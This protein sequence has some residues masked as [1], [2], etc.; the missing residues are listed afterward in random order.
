MIRVGSSL[1]S[2][3]PDPRSLRF[4][5]SWLC[6]FTMR[7]TA[8]ASHWLNRLVMATLL[9]ADV[10]IG[11][12]WVGSPARAFSSPVFDTAKSLFSIDAYGIALLLSVAVALTAFVTAG[13]SWI[14]GWLAGP[15]IGGQWMFWSLLFAQGAIG[16]AGGS[17]TASTF[18]LTFA[19]LHC[20]A[21]LGIA[22]SVYLPNQRPR[23]R[24][25]DPRS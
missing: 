10:V 1:P 19:V 15:L 3:G 24:T 16:R 7:L 18:A 4:V 22:G 8:W 6:V 21:G 11:L 23:R 5:Q 25:T 20:L 17:L 14:S 12:I 9:L 13:R 2:K